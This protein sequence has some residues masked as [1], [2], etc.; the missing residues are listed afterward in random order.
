MPEVKYDVTMQPCPVCKKP[1]NQLVSVNDNPDSLSP[2]PGD[3]TVCGN[4]SALLILG[5]KLELGL[6]TSED[7]LRIP[8]DDIKRH[9][10]EV[11]ASSET[12]H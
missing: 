10:A 5:P 8:L 12:E 6:P 9:Q 3:P 4:C 1:Q 2:L 7:L 11:L